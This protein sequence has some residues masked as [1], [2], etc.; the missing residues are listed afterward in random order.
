MNRIAA[1]MLLD[2]RSLSVINRIALLVSTVAAMFFYF[3]DSPLKGL[4]VLLPAFWVLSMIN[5]MYALAEKYRIDM[6]QATLP[7][8]RGDIVKARYLFFVC[9]QAV[10]ML[11]PLLI[12]IIF[13]Q[14]NEKVYYVAVAFLTV[15]FFAAV[16]YPLYFKIGVGKAKGV[17]IVLL[18]AFFTGFFGSPGF[19]KLFWDTMLAF[20]ASPVKATAAGLLLL[21]LSYLLS[22]KIY[23]TRDL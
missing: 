2:F 18:I 8:T 13:S 23:Q 15:S 10:I 3:D 16:M 17:L 19:R 7:L 4:A 9:M 21:G 6:L 11:P 5:N 12:N 14:D 20:T 1:V 22:L